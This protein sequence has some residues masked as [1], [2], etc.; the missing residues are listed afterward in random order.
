MRKE[1]GMRNE[2]GMRKAGRRTVLCILTLAE[3]FILVTSRMR[4]SRYGGG[5]GVPLQEPVV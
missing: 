5:G 4:L 2:G 3:I 1:G